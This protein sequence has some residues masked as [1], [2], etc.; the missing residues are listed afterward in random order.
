MDQLDRMN[1]VRKLLYENTGCTWIDE[2]ATWFNMHN[3]SPKTRTVKR[4]MTTLFD[5][6]YPSQ[7]EV[8]QPEEEE[9][10]TDESDWTKVVEKEL[11]GKKKG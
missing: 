2:A 8:T 9:D 5:L 4:K 10:I 3:Q 1:E 6:K 11:N 7:E